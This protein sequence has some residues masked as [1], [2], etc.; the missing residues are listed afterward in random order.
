MLPSGGS[1]SWGYVSGSSVN[2]P[3]SFPPVS[4]I[5]FAYKPETQEL[6]L[7]LLTGI[8]VNGNTCAAPQI[9]SGIK[10][11]LGR[12]YL[13]NTL[14]WI[15]GQPVALNWLASS[16]AVMYVNCSS[17]LTNFNTIETR[18]LSAPCTLTTCT[19]TTSNSNITACNSYTWTNGITYT[20]SGVYTYSNT[21]GSG[22]LNVDT[23]HLT[24]NNCNT[25]VSLT[26]YLQGY[27]ASSGL[28]YPA[29]FNQGGTNNS[30]VVDNITLELHSAVSPY[31][32]ISSSTGILQT[33]GTASIQYSGLFSGNYYLVVKHRNT[34]ETW[35]SN[36]L[37]IN[38]GATVNY[39]FSTDSTKAFG[40]NL[41]KVENGIWALYSGDINQDRKID[42]SDMHDLESDINNS[43]F[44]IYK[45]D[46]NGD[47][48]VDI[49]DS[50]IVEQNIA[51][52]R[53]SIFPN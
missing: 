3:S 4:N 20:N 10:K 16:G 41:V 43:L 18:S 50:P 44:G 7:S 17:T 14:P 48:N 24:I 36:P 40:N 45:T 47:A 30:A 21:N 25:Y 19:V 6:S 27:Y 8:Y 28:M 11:T 51:T 53:I 39:N 12:F 29:L 5:A 23:L 35:S 52:N 9:A 34:L 37:T 26:T 33:N 49:F 1:V 31:N 42:I 32:L 22:C 2:F 38:A 15:I 13:R 46:I